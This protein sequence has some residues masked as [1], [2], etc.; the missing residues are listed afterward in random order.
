MYLSLQCTAFF[1]Y[2][3]LADG[4]PST[5]EDLGGTGALDG[6][7]T[8][9]IVEFNFSWGYLLMATGK[10]DFGDRIERALF[11]AGMGAVR[12][13]WSGL[14]YISCPNQ[15]HIARNSCQVGHVGTAAA[16]YGP[17]SDHRPEFKFVT[18]CCAGNVN[19]MVPHYVQRMWM[20]ADKGGLAAVLY[21]PSRVR[22]LAG[23]RDHPVE[24][25]EETSY[26]FSE[27]IIFHILC[28]HPVS[29][30]LHLRIPIWCEHPRLSINGKS[31]PLPPM[32]NGFIVLNRTHANDDT[33]ILDVPMRV[34]MGH[35]SD[36]GIFLERGPLLYSLNPQEDWDPIMMPEFE[37]TSPDYF[38]MWGATA[39]S[40]WNYAVAID[41]N[42][43]LDKQIYVYQKLVDVDAW[44]N[45][46][47]RLKVP[48]RRIR[49]W[50]LLHPKGDDPDWFRTPPLSSEKNDLGAMEMI[51][52]V[53][54][55]STQL[56]LTVFPSASSG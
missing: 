11:N 15:L 56:R 53:P 28:G 19:R 24:I 22:A 45:P 39:R 29:F 25:I 3:M 27:R 16:L 36:S 40:P 38:P 50:G 32:E 14:Q 4:T 44:S 23:E 51:T 12:N 26:P 7:E 6:H 52:L 33:I 34:A 9:D 31:I 46:S 13:D 20:N 18:S 42:A 30:P 35:S 54:L 5:T 21:G 37:I 2:H 41:E 17:N 1:K 8:C 49:G 48:A 43:S 47:I 55:G 10:G